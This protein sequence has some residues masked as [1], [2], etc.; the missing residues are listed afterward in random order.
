MRLRWIAACVVA[1]AAAVAQTPEGTRTRIRGSVETVDG[2]NLIVRTGSGQSVAIVMAPNFGV[3]G[4]VKKDLADIKPGDFVASTS[5]READ[6]TLRAL[7][8]HYLRSGSSEGQFPYDLEPNS[9]MTNAVVAGVSTAANGRML[10]VTYKG[11]VAN[12]LVPT[13]APVVAFVPGDLSLLRPGAA[14]V[15]FATARPDGTVT[16]TGATVEK[17]GVKPPM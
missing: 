16:A 15:I 1:S 7:E 8:V 12:I 2:P 11:S 6:G 14:I 4:V 3:S 10:R 5:V 13:E 17:D 9:L